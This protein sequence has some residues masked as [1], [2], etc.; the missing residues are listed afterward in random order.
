M[1][2]PPQLD[3]VGAFGRTTDS[4]YSVSGH[5]HVGTEYRF[6]DSPLRRVFD[7]GRK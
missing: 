6:D 3:D 5:A 1:A 7:I 2:G 4:V